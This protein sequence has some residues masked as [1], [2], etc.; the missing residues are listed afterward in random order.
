MDVLKIRKKQWGPKKTLF[1]LAVLSLL[2]AGNWVKK[3]INLA[4]MV[5]EFLP[6]MAG[7]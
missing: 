7:I 6:D 2:C 3:S 5:W 1:F 4:G